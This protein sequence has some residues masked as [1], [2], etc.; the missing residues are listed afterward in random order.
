[1]IGGHFQPS[2]YY[3]NSAGHYYWINYCPL[4]HHYSCLSYNPKG[5]VEGE[6]TCKICDS[7]FDGTSGADK[8]GSGAR[9]WL[10]PATQ[11]QIDIWYHP[12]KQAVQ[13]QQP[14]TQQL[15]PAE[16]MMNKLNQ[17]KDTDL[18]GMSFD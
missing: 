10:K 16:L 7:D 17:Y 6:L 15:S 14:V 12:Q 18:L 4:C 13:S 9:G 1:M 8:C 5:T 3:A 11:E 2:G